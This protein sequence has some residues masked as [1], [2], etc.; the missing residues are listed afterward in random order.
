MFENPIIR[1]LVSLS[2]KHSFKF[3]RVISFDMYFKG[4]CMIYLDD[5]IHNVTTINCSM[6]VWVHASDHLIS[7]AN[8]INLK[9]TEF[10]FKH[11]NI[12]MWHEFLH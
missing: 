11:T 1:N 10:R 5:I 6:S 9:K 12:A 7:G 3:K 2:F 8:Q 4:L